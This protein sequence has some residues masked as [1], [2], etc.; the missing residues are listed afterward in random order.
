MPLSEE[1]VIFGRIRALDLP[2]LPAE[3]GATTLE[4]ER[5]FFHYRPLIVS[6]DPDANHRM[7]SIWDHVRHRQNTMVEEF[8]NCFVFGSNFVVDAEQNVYFDSLNFRRGGFEFYNRVIRGASPAPMPECVFADGGLTIHWPK[9]VMQAAVS[10]DD[11]VYLLTPIEP[12]NWGRWIRQVLPRLHYVKQLDPNYR[13]LL[14]CAASWQTRFLQFCDIDPSRIIEHDP[15]KLYKIRSLKMFRHS[16]VD[17]TVS[18]NDMDFYQSIARKYR[19]IG[20][21]KKMYS[22]LDEASRRNTNITECWKTRTSSLKN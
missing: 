11:P 4:A 5:R 7:P 6:N 9:D 2:E 14:R 21:Q 18:C 10:I 8:S 3:F 13:I 17:L 1:G 20:G 12:D 15:F 22:C 19:K 16:S